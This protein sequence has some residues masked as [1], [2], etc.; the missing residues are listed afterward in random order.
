LALEGTN[1]SDAMTLDHLT[2]RDDGRLYAYDGDVDPWAGAVVT[3]ADCKVGD[4]VFLNRS[5]WV[6]SPAYWTLHEIVPVTVS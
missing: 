2:P 3:L 6:A 5:N 1:L 4:L